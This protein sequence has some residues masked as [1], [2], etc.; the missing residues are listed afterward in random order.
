MEEVPGGGSLSLSASSRV[1]FVGL[2]L[3]L[4][5]SAL[6]R[7]TGEVIPLTRGEFAI[8]RVFATQPGRVIS[9]DTLLDALAN[10]RFEPFDRS[11]DVLVGRLRRKIEPDPRRPA[12][13]VTVV[14][15]GYKFAAAV[16]TERPTTAREPGE[17]AD[18][19]APRQAER[20]HMTELCAELLPAEGRTLP[21]DPEDLHHAIDAFRRCVAEALALHAGE[22]GESH[23]REVVA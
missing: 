15:S 3:D 7:E 11:I 16:H 21:S 19:T 20:R 23:G 13:I 18:K 4:D 1:R 5:A 9:R 10:R 14:G 2:V 22:I 8:L 12:I 6:A 17:T